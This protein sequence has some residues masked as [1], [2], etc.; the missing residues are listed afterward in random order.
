VA[1]SCR[2]RRGDRREQDRLLWLGYW[3]PGLGSR[4][5]QRSHST[6]AGL[7]ARRPVISGARGQLLAQAH[8]CQHRL[9]NRSSGR[10]L[11]GGTE[12]ASV[13]GSDCRRSTGWFRW[14][15]RTSYS[16][17][18]V[19]P[20]ALDRSVTGG[21]AGCGRG[22]TGQAI[23]TDQDRAMVSGHWCDAGRACT[24]SQQTAMGRRRKRNPLVHASIRTTAQT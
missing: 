6:G 22:K 4:L 13:R 15:Y 11:S 14:R 7:L 20:I 1:R 5:P 19:P 12:R 24:S 23:G 21:V 16:V 2:G 9:G 8:A 18:T 10:H 3:H 17:S